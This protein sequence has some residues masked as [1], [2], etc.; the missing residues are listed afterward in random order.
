LGNSRPDKLPPNAPNAANNLLLDNGAINL[1]DG[2]GLGRRARI[3][4]AE[5]ADR[6]E[7]APADPAA[8]AFVLYFARR[9]TKRRGDNA[10]IGRVVDSGANGACIR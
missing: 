2:D 6:A 10:G 4:R 3:Y 8:S 5:C 1:R 9:V 7:R